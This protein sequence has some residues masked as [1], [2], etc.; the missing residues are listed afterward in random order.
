MTA[1]KPT[2][3]SRVKR[4][5]DRGHYDE[6]S[7]F[8]ILDAALIAHVGYVI[9]GQPY[10]TPTNFWRQGRKLYWHGSSA[11]RMLRHQKGGVPVCVTVTHFDG[12]VLAR[13]GFNSSINYRCVMAFG[14]A[15]II[16]D[17]AE[18][19]RQLDLFMD[20]V[21]PGRRTAL[22]AST[23]QEI[24]ATTVIGMEIEEA[25][26]KTRAGPPKDDEPDYALDCWAGVIPLALIVGAPEPDPRLAPGTP[27]PD[28]LKDFAVQRRF[29]EI[30]RKRD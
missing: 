15:H 25:S 12:L 10:V 22:R 1:F 18:K 21:A 9:D 27:F 28:H 8:P 26:A 29:D 2:Q 24:K 23:K 7:I 19:E 20:R 13:S 30:M 5:H 4:L 17:L 3:R 14:R 11:S 16:D 6:V